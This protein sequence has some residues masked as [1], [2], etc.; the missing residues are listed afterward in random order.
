MYTVSIWRLLCGVKLCI[1]FEVL[2][3]KLNLECDWQAPFECS[4]YFA[5]CHSEPHL[6][7]KPCRRALLLQESEGSTPGM[8]ETLPVYLPHSPGLQTHRLLIST[9]PK[10][11][12]PRS[13]PIL[14]GSHQVW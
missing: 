3:G 7:H 6:M 1:C 9:A 14:L 12:S 5:E 11:Q 10:G 8:V 13:N 2:L 4:F